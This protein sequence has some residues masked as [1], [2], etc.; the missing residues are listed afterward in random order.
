MAITIQ[1]GKVLSGP[2]LG[3]AV[4]DKAIKE[5]V[6]LEEGNLVESRK[7]DDIYIPSNY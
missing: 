5:D 1:S 2:F 6:A 3:K 7:M 4:N